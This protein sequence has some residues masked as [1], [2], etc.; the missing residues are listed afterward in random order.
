MTTTDITTAQATVN[1]VNS[2]ITRIADRLVADGAHRGRAIDAATD[3]VLTRM[4]ADRPT[5]FGA[6]VRSL[7]V[8]DAQA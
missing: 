5:A 7:A 1:T 4:A 8:L 6:Y 2:A 3:Y